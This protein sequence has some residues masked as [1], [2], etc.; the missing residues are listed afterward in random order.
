MHVY[1]DETNMVA[2]TT[3]PV[4]KLVD[5]SGLD[6][7]RELQRFTGN[8]PDLATVLRMDLASITEFVNCTF[9]IKCSRVASHQIVRHRLCSIVQVSQ[10]F[11]HQVPEILLPRSVI[12]KAATTDDSIVIDVVREAYELYQQLIDKGLRR[13]L[14]R[15]VLP[16]CFVTELYLHAIL[17]EIAYILKVRMCRRAQPETRYIAIRMYL[18]LVSRAGE[19]R[20]ALGPYCAV[21]GHCKYR[22][23]LRDPEKLRSCRVK[24][25]KEALFEHG[26]ATEVEEMDILIEKLP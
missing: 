19:L 1:A 4:V 26:S 25:Y 18:E 9:Y 20:T 12:L 14:A 3:T 23:D 15:Y 13:E 22:P 16:Q 24:G 5:I 21:H 2:V 7:Y 8:A 17:R 11:S 10:R 6:L